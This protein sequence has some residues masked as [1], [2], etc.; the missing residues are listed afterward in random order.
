MQS[1]SF[2]KYDMS[3][4][5]ASSDNSFPN[6]NIEILFF[7]NANI[8]IHILVIVNAKAN[9]QNNSNTNVRYIYIFHNT[10]F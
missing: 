5:E 4:E 9:V 10:N 8:E 3:I 6:A 1:Y 7:T 2:P